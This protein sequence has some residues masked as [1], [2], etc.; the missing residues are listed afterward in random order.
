MEKSDD[1]TQMGS[2]LN[3]MFSRLYY[4]NLVVELK[5]GDVS[6]QEKEVV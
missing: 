1:Y 4:L 6:M 3:L 2:R 5:E